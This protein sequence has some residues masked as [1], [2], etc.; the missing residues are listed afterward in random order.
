MNLHLRNEICAREVSLTIFCCYAAAREQ[1][2]SSLRWESTRALRL[3]PN[4]AFDLKQIK[5]SSSRFCR[6]PS[7]RQ[8][9]FLITRGNHPRSCLTWWLLAPS[10]KH[11]RNAFKRQTISHFNIGNSVKHSYFW[12]CA[13]NPLLKEQCELT[14][15]VRKAQNILN[16]VQQSGSASI[17][18]FALD[19]FVKEGNLKEVQFKLTN[20]QN[21]L[22]KGWFD[23]LDT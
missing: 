9:R 18:W 19:T 23:L 7:A 11:T 5:L 3:P 14:R 17:G 10:L 1:V 6:T 21:S 8:S 22:T 15:K 20:L 13:S 12:F 2:A 16:F 4:V